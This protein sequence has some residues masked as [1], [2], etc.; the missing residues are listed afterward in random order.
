MYNTII[1][2]GQLS[3]VGLFPTLYVHP[4][5]EE[6]NGNM[7]DIITAEACLLRKRRLSLA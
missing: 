4:D 3:R 2:A 1:R 5:F 7:T 6:W